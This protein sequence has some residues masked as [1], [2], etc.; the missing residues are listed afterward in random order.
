MFSI[1][2]K[3]KKDANIPKKA[4]IDTV[5]L[6]PA[7]KERFRKAVEQIQ[8]KYQIE[9]FDIPNLV[10]DE[11]NC[12]VIMFLRVSLSDLKQ[13]NFVNSIIQTNINALCVVEYTDGVEV[14]Y[15]FADK[16]LNKQNKKEVV[17]ENEYITTKLL[18]EFQND[19]KTLFNLY[20]IITT[21]N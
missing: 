4:F 17:I 14:Q 16:R 8:L 13:V 9:G 15:S 2:E 6:L 18:L 21:C 10:N 11:Y 19:K 1:P 3:Y 5:G 7:S 20:I 12:Q